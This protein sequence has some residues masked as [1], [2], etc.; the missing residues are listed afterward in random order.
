MRGV[1][2]LV[3]L[4]RALS[5][6]FLKSLLSRNAC[7]SDM[8]IC[9]QGLVYLTPTQQLAQVASAGMSFLWCVI[10]KAVHKVIIL[11]PQKKKI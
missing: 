9:V 5:S 8:I 2:M 10:R 6:V 1:L 11:Q 4:A 3:K 7:T